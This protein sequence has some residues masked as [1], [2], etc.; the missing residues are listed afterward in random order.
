MKRAESDRSRQLWNQLLNSART[1][2]QI[3]DNTVTAA[4]SLFDL[5]SKTDLSSYSG[6]HDVLQKLRD[7]AVAEGNKAEE[8][9]AQ[10][11]DIDQQNIID[12]HATIQQTSIIVLVVALLLAVLVS[13][14]LYRSIRSEEHTSE[15]Q[16]LMR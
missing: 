1:R 6:P 15:L 13:F 16:S 4:G 11:A 12:L 2:A 9:T 8:L 5:F 14:L 10:L 3:H 7:S